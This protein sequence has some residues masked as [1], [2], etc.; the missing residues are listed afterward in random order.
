LLVIGFNRPDYLKDL[1]SLLSEI[2]PSRLYL[3]VDGPRDSS[4][5]I[6]V[7]Q[8]RLVISEIDWDCEI[9]TKFNESN[10]GCKEA[11]I[12]AIDWIFSYE[13]AAII[14]EDDVRPSKSF[15]PYCQELLNKFKNNKSIFMISGLNLNEN[16]NKKVSYSF[17]AIPS[18]W[19]WATWREKWSDYSPNIENWKSD[20]GVKGLRHFFGCSWIEAYIFGKFLFGRVA[21]GK[22]D[23]WDYQLIY[24]LIK[25]NRLGVIPTRNLISNIGFGSDSTHTKIKPNYLLPADEIALP[26]NN[27]FVARN[28][29]NDLWILKNAYGIVSY[30]KYI[31][32]I[33]RLVFQKS[34]FS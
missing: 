28:R 3:A 2:K 7:N 11:V 10:L 30:R 26:L 20:I 23:T 5:V 19:G 13:E 14:L 16:L 4:E 29:E 31:L 17:S 25:F 32:N 27:S 34:T 33:L 24:H 9:R 1:L 22:L 18:P 8:S 21:D 12:S 15:F 6:I